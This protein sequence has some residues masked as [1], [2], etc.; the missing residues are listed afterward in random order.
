MD[1]LKSGSCGSQKSVAHERARNELRAG[2]RTSLSA[3]AR[4]PFTARRSRVLALAVVS[5]LVGCVL[6]GAGLYIYQKRANATQT[7]IALRQS[8][9]APWSHALWNA[10]RKLIWS[11]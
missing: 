11:S 6:G 3:D 4:T 2:T 8:G 1:P 10:S 5:A 7:R 9:W